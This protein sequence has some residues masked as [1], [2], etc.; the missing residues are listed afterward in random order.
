LRVRAVDKQKVADHPESKFADSIEQRHAQLCRIEHE[1][2]A[3]APITPG[4]RAAFAAMAAAGTQITVV[5][6]LTNAA[7]RTFLVMHRL[8]QHARHL[9]GRVGP[10]P[11]VLPPALD[12]I[13]V[14]IRQ[15]A[16]PVESCLFVASTDADLVAARAAGVDT[17]RHRCPTTSAATDRQ[18]SH[19][20][21]GS[22]HCP[23]QYR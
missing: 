7:V 18:R 11:S 5:A 2:V 8:Q 23:N 3:S 6:S 20:I 10:D 12:L 4:V 21:P 16:V 22:T 9:V 1:E 15:R 14:A 17:I 19:P 13:T